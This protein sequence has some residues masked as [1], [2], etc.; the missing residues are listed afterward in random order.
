MDVANCGYIEPIMQDVV[1]TGVGMLSID[2]PSSLRKLVEVSQKKVVVM[3][4]VA[5]SLFAWGRRRRS[6]RQ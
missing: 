6:S 4:N 3:G 5:T 2:E 1:S